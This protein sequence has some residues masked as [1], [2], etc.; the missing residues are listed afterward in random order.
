[1][2]NCTNSTLTPYAGEW[3]VRQ[4]LHFAR[5]T[6]F[7][8]TYTELQAALTQTPQD[9]IQ[10]KL[11][12]IDA[13]YTID[14]PMYDNNNDPFY[15]KDVEQSGTKALWGADA[16]SCYL[17][18][19]GPPDNTDIP[20]CTPFDNLF[21]QHNPDWSGGENEPHSYMVRTRRAIYDGEWMGNLSKQ[22]LRQKMILFWSNHFVIQS[23]ES[24][25]PAK[26]HE[27]YKTIEQ[28][29]FGDF[30]EFT[31]AIGKTIAMLQYLNGANNSADNLNENY[32][33]ELYEL[34]TL[35][36]N[37]GYTQ[38][39][40]IETA[41]AFT[42]WTYNPRSYPMEP[43]F[44]DWAHPHQDGQK[45]VFGQTIQR[46]GDERGLE[47]D[48]VIDVLFAQRSNEIATFICGEIYKLFVGYDIVDSIID[49]M[50]IT[51][52]NNNFNIRP[53]VEQLLFSEHFFDEH[54]ICTKVKSPIDLLLSFAKDMNIDIEQV[55]D[56]EY[57]HSPN[58]PNYTIGQ[59]LS[60]VTIA[61]EV[62][63]WL[64]GT[65]RDI[66][67]KHILLCGASRIGQTLFYPPN[68]AG[69]PG[70]KSWINANALTELWYVFD[71]YVQIL[72]TLCFGWIGK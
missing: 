4:V 2:N 18:G 67:W 66:K 51:F 3:T 47:Y 39:D 49:E 69:W 31:R 43:Y 56:F 27:Y 48:D 22:G 7:S 12:E 16:W 72:L 61:S 41:K 52:L 63:G 64:R 65:G 33:R 53:V 40:I 34:F 23:G 17:P 55:V 26:V 21:A 38:E 13:P 68:V 71:R 36:V 20:S 45:T 6:G 9:Y 32:A 10:A 19:G 57:A 15:A 42:G 29:A 58:N 50:K 8:L 44:E 59:E 46:T 70:D 54:N 28:Y 37:N 25:G 11:N 62:A 14:D 24:I 60:L 30:K 1:M 35:G 5:R